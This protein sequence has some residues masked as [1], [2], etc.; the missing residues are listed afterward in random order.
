MTRELPIS[1]NAGAVH[2]LTIAGPIAPKG[3]AGSLATF[4]L[5]RCLHGGYTDEV[6]R[7]Q[8]RK[9]SSAGI[10]SRITWRASF[11]QASKSKTGSF[12]CQTLGQGKSALLQACEAGP[13]YVQVKQKGRWYCRVFE[14]LMR[15]LRALSRRIKA[16]RQLLVIMI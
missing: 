13:A 5:G 8:A 9:C 16:T 15:V 2:R 10:G 12:R 4:R 3:C 11:Y 6:C 1:R 7:V 14:Q